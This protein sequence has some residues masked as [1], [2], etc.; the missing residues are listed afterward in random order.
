LLTFDEA[1]ALVVDAIT[2][3]APPD[4][5]YRLDES[6]TIEKPWGWVFFYNSQRYLDTHD[7][8]HH[9]LGN[10]PY[11]V[12]K[13]TGEILVTGTAE[14]IDFYIAEYEASLG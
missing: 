8:N 10:A 11:I 3:L 13:T 5:P 1:R 4:D 2:E 7:D 6:A 14:D 12:N 9:L